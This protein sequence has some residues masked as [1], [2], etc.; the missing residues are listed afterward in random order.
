VVSALVWRFLFDDRAGPATG[1]LAALAIVPEHFV[2]LADSRAAWVPV[3]VADVW[4][5]TPFVALLVLSG[6][7]QIDAGLYEAA[8]MD[9]ATRAQQ[10]REITLPLLK[11][12][13]L[14]SVLFR[15]LDAFRVFDLVYV[16]TGGGPGTATEPIS[17]YAF[18]ALLQNLRFGYGSALATT[19]FAVTFVLALLYVRLS[20]AALLGDDR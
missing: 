6:L 4:R 17:L 15:A 13:L 3:V 20:R 12:A 14:V 7:Q 19:V 1:A 9:G 18:S 10:F 2:W 11:P 5:M 8:R 16:L